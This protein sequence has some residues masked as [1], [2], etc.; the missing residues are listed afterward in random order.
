M[1]LMM[2]RYNPAGLRV[3]G[4]AIEPSLVQLIPDL[5]NAQCLTRLELYVITDESD[6][7]VLIEFITAHDQRWG[8]IREIKLQGTGS[9][10]DPVRLVQCLSQPRLVDLSEWYHPVARLDRIASESLET[11]YLRT[12]ERSPSEISTS[13]LES[14]RSL[15]SLG[16]HITDPD[17]F[18]PFVLERT[19]G[20]KH[21]SR[22]YGNSSHGP[23]D[24]EHG[25]GDRMPLSHINF[26]GEEP[27]LATCLADAV[28]AFQETLEEITAGSWV[29][30]EHSERHVP[31]AWTF[32]L[33]LL[34]RL[35][36]QGQIVLAFDLDALY[37]CPSLRSLSLDLPA[38]THSV[39]GHKLAS[40][41]SLTRLR[42]LS[43]EGKWY[44]GDHLLD[45]LSEHLVS[46]VELNLDG[47]LGPTSQGLLS[48]L[49][50]MRNLERYCHAPVVDGHVAVLMSM[51]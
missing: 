42:K 1:K 11:L 5:L 12:R 51:P 25:N 26:G 32:S 38:L 40:L 2:T 10:H 27:A 6:I 28:S 39:S 4:I 41:A 37:W 9:K 44:V 24:K 50:R 23:G 33:P 45:Y 36:L 18:K 15:R 7:D 31:L 30:A 20:S 34:T 49:K 8:S 43:L 16:M 14:C 35:D 46:L 48:A 29:F 21:S 13:F 47:C 19:G 17:I 3:F 22:G